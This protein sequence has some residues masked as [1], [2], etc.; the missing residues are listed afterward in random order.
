MGG[1][2][3]GTRQ[4]CYVFLPGLILAASLLRS[5]GRSSLQCV[6]EDGE[7][8]HRLEP[9]FFTPLFVGPR[10]R[11]P[12]WLRSPLSAPHPQEPWLHRSGAAP[13]TLDSYPGAFS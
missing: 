5:W 12:I 1:G 10:D 11:G 3:P 6:V 9:W 2:G 8:G 13:Q 7:G 4:C